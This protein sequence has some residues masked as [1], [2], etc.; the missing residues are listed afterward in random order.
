MAKASERFPCPE[1]GKI[2]KAMGLQ[3]HIRLKHKIK[4]VERFV[5]NNRVEDSSQSLPE[6]PLP[7]QGE[8]DSVPLWLQMPKLSDHD[9]YILRA[10]YYMSHPVE[11]QKK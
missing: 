8:K 3:N 2:C 7:S 1:C 11:A 9:K 4:V 6:S 10:R 5:F